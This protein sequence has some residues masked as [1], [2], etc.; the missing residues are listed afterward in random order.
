MIVPSPRPCLSVVLLT[1][2]AA[3]IVVPAA[4]AAKPRVQELRRGQ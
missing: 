1:T 4:D 3:L 2:T